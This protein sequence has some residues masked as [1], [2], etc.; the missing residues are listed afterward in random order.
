[1]QCFSSTC[2]PVEILMH[3]DVRDKNLPPALR[4]CLELE[5]GPPLCPGHGLP[6]GWASK[7]PRGRFHE[8]L[9]PG[10]LTPNGSNSSDLQV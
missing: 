1:M 2:Y 3:R 9:I 7:S 10:Q 6:G 4:I 8:D 5:P